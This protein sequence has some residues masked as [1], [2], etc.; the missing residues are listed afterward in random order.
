VIVLSGKPES[1]VVRGKGKLMMGEEEKRK[2]SG[3]WGGPE[4]GGEIVEIRGQVSYSDRGI[5]G[6]KG[7]P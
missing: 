7:N 3:A 4:A 1:V 5:G 2:G 6:G